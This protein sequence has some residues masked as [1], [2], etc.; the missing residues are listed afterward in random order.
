MKIKKQPDLEERLIKVE[1]ML[2]VLLQQI[3][4]IQESV[5]PKGY[6]PVETLRNDVIECMHSLSQG[7]SGVL[8][9]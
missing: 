3:S 7:K 6:A 2:Q 4:L 1:A 5:D 8:D 9:I